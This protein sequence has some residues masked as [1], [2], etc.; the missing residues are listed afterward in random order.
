M[1]H[2]VARPP[3]GATNL[4]VIKEGCAEL[5]PDVV[6]GVLSCS[7]ADAQAMNAIGLSF[8]AERGRWNVR[9]RREREGKTYLYLSK[10]QTNGK[11]RAIRAKRG[12]AEMKVIA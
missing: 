11:T 12:I 8:P 3:L 6:H 5:G 4:N 9:G 2:Y 10:T 1:S 7:P